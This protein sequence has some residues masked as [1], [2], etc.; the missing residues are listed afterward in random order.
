MFFE[1]KILGEENGWQDP[2]DTINLLKNDM[3]STMSLDREN[4]CYDY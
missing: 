3:F 2:P 4:D 1:E